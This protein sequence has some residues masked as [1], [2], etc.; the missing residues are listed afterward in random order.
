MDLPL[1]AG[2]AGKLFFAQRPGMAGCI[3]AAPA[4]PLFAVYAHRLA[5]GYA[6]RDY[7][8][9]G[10]DSKVVGTMKF[11]G[12]LGIPKDSWDEDRCVDHS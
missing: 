8:K 12:R 1:G 4:K 11:T 6:L 3:E 7:N 2:R 5:F 9:R 10:T